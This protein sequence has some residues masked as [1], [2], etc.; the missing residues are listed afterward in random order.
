MAAIDRMTFALAA[1]QRER[2]LAEAEREHRS[3]GSLV[4][5][6]V[7]DGLAHR[8]RPAPQ[9]AMQELSPED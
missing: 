7:E 8:D 4:R 3:V 9:S 2:L 1:T 6:F 5:E